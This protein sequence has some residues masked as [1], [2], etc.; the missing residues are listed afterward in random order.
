M[1]GT[2]QLALALLVALLVV[3]LPSSQARADA[4]DRLPKLARL[5]AEITAARG[6]LAYV[7]LR[8]LWAE[9]DRGDPAQVEEVL[10]AV[11]NE[12]G[13]PAPV[14]TYAALLEA[15]ARRR[16]GDLDGARARIDRLGYVGKWMLV[17]PF[18]NEGKSGH[19]TAYDPEKE[20]Q[21]PLDLVRDYDGKEHKPV[22]WRMLP[23]VSPYGWTDLGVFVRPAES[24][25]GYLTT[26]VRDPSLAKGAR[27]PAT[28]WAGNTGAIRLYWNGV[29]ILEWYQ[30][31][32]A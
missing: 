22:R 30:A 14:R 15:Y 27:H 12:A 9:W 18:D 3:A 31:A 8:K 28:V 26:F 2:T 20:Q 24:T 7:G 16:R 11:A 19:G 5:H 21:V 32:K 6:P 17:G 23:P 10:H 1:R 13:E 25:C 29:E 4:A